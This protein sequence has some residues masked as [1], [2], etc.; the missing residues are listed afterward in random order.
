MTTSH[1]RLSK[2]QRTA[3]KLG[4]GNKNKHS[5]RGQGLNGGHEQISHINVVEGN[6]LQMVSWQQQKRKVFSLD[7]KEVSCSGPAIF[8]YFVPDIWSIMI[9]CCFSMF[10][11]DSGGK[12]S[13][14][15]AEHL[16]VFER[17][18]ASVK[19]SELD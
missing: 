13:R 14:P 10:C 17:H 4:P 2:Q 12:K 3:F 15:V 18:E 8:L 6:V 1:L 7:L 11:S 9:K 5:H 16:R 19:I